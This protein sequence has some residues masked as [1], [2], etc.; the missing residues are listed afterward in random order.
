M[1]RGIPSQVLVT[2]FAHNGAGVQSCAVVRY[3]PWGGRPKLNNEFDHVPKMAGMM[4]DHFK[5]PTFFHVF[6][7]TI[8]LFIS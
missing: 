7:W 1:G 3:H 5:Q 2:G 6:W 8:F 4:L